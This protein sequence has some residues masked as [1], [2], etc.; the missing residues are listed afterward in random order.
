MPEKL[1]LGRYRPVGQ[2]GSGG[3]AEVSLA[4]DTRLQRRVAIKS[5]RLDEETA[6]MVESADDMSAYDLDRIPGLAEARTAAMFQDPNIAG[7]L[8]FGVKDGFAYFIMEYVDGITLADLLAEF[9][10]YITLDVVAAVFAGVAHALDVAHANQV[11]HLDIKP[12]NILINHQGEV[13]VT[14]FGLAELSGSSGFSKATGGTIGY[15][16]LEQMRLEPLDARCD[17]WALASVV[18]EMLTG[19]NPFL[20]DDLA[21]A[22]TAI[23]QADILLPSIC[24]PELDEEADEV[25]FYALDP[26][27]GE[28]YDS[29]ADFAE[30]L[31][32][33]LGSI[34]RGTRQLAHLVGEAKDDCRET[35]DEE[36]SVM[37]SRGG[38]IPGLASVGRAGSLLSSDTFIRILGAVSCGMLAYLAFVGNLWLEG[39][40][41]F[42]L[43]IA[44]VVLCLAG[45]VLPHLGALLCMI[46]L[47]AAF[48]SQ[49]SY[50][51]AVLI[52]VPAIAWWAML[53]RRGIDEA[54]IMMVPVSLG[55]FGCA[56]VSP[57]AGG[58]NLNAKQA[59]GNTAASL[60]LAVVLATLSSQQIAGWDI[61]TVFPSA[62]SRFNGSDQV[63][64][65]MV[66]QPGFW[67]TAA[68]WLL[69]T[70]VV[71]LFSGEG[72]MVRRSLGLAAGAFLLA[73]GCV[74]NTYLS[75]AG[76]ALVPPISEILVFVSVVAISFAYCI[77]RPHR[78]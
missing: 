49:A 9:R 20:A 74:A 62:A 63:L 47:A 19:H 14:D 26:E 65:S 1:I 58:L 30:E 13:K 64:F 72:G 3:F 21:G 29:V 70:G 8:D 77:A 66:V 2:I 71:A 33:F 15:M 50:F 25:I 52:V 11:L 17:E 18:Y 60:C 42:A 44:M 23:E 57:L 7:V 59:L 22:Q 12:G 34:R 76:A 75:S 56:A 54:A 36:E 38:K 16:P 4:W 27:K 68:S 46:A 48:A 40:P 28:R 67:I 24:R 10:D 78:G 32:P 73:A 31:Q 45:Y 41:V 6:A 61:L 43:P 51:C 69:A 55:S 39:L 53:G 37:A 5:L 35:E